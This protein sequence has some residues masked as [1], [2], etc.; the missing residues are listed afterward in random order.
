MDN[1]PD[2]DKFVKAMIASKGEDE[3]ALNAEIN[4]ALKDFRAQQQQGSRR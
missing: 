3:G 2:D 1:I 4:A